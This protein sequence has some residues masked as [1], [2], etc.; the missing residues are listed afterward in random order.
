MSLLTIVN[1]GK[2][3]TRPKAARQVVFDNFSLEFKHGSIITVVGANGCG[4]TTLLNCI[5]NLT[6]YERGEIKIN[7]LDGSLATIGFVFQNYRESLLPWLKNIDNIACAL[8]QPEM[9]SRFQQYNYIKSWAEEANIILPWNVYPYQ[10]SGGQQQL[11]AL[12]REFINQPEILLLDEP[13]AALDYE[14][15]LVWRQQLET[16]WKKFP[17][18]IILVSHDLEEAIYLADEVIVLGDQPAKIFGR[19]LI[20][21]PRPRTPALLQ[22]E[23]FFQLHCAVLRSFMRAAAIL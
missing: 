16:L 21:L 1:L 3:Y 22:S 8:K 10:C 20:D 18:T 4:K 6:T 11:L 7:G 14:K 9:S 17:A 2:T 5:A 19:H 12:A 13:F 15:R 23:A